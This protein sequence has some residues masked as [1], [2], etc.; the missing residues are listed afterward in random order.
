MGTAGLPSVLAHL[1]SLQATPG[2]ELLRC[3]L[4]VEPA[5]VGA[6]N[7]CHCLVLSFLPLLCGPAFPHPVAG[8]IVLGLASRHKVYARLQR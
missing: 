5:A 1:S 6:E 8:T 4:P 7:L 3:L 2:L